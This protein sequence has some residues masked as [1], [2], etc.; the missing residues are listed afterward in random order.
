MPWMYEAER[1]FSWRE[2]VK[3]CSVMEAE[4]RG[5]TDICR[6][7]ILPLVERREWRREWEE[8]REVLVSGDI[9]G[10]VLCRKAGSQR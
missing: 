6:K 2:V 3:S 10:A 8:E 4:V 5:E 1:R 9:L 7:L